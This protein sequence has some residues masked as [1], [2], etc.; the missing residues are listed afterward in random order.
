M[1]QM[2]K[3]MVFAMFERLNVVI[4]SSE[5]SIRTRA[6]AAESEFNLTREQAKALSNE[7]V[8]E[9]LAV[10]Q[11]NKER[12][13]RAFLKRKL[14]ETGPMH[15]ITD[16]GSTNVDAMLWSGRLMIEISR[17]DDPCPLAEAAKRVGLLDGYDARKFFAAVKHVETQW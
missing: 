6:I 7:W 13:V 1:N 3:K 5:T 8:R 12:E 15:A 17:A 14:L 9:V 2:Q 16:D 10:Q 4:L 11:D